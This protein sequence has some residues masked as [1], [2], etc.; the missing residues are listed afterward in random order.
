MS[1]SREVKF[2]KEQIE[3]VEDRVN[4]LTQASRTVLELLLMK[5]SVGKED[6]ERAVRDIERLQTWTQEL[7]HEERSLEED[8]PPRARN[9]PRRFRR[10]FGED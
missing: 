9:H 3:E 5:G 6:L 1:G 10:V 8:L 7:H 4:N 2:S